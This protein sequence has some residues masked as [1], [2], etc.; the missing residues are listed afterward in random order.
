MRDPGEFSDVSQVVREDDFSS[1]A[2]RLIFAAVS[3]LIVSGKPAHPK[4]VADLLDAKERMVDV[5]G[6]AYIIDIWESFA[7]SKSAKLFAEIVRKK[8]NLRAVIEA[9]EVI[10]EAA[11]H[12]GAVDTEIVAEAEALIFDLSRDSRRTKTLDWQQCV[13]NALTVIDKRAG[14]VS[15][16]QD[17]QSILTGFPRLDHDTCGFHRRELIILAA[18]PSVGKTLVALN[19]VDNIAARGHKV[20]FASIEQG[21]VELVHRMLSRR[22]GIDSFKFRSGRFSPMEGD[23]LLNAK[24]AM[25]NHKLW[26]NDDSTQTL[27][28]V[29]S[30][31][32]RLKQRH[33]LDLVVVDYLQLMKAERRHKGTR[34]DEVGQL[35]RGLK[36]LA[37]DLDV[38]VMCLAQLN[39]GSENRTDRTPK[40]SDLR[41]S[42]EIEQD[43]DT[44][45][46]LHKP[47][48]KDKN[49][50]TDLLDFLIEKQRNGPCGRVPMIHKKATFEIKEL[51]ESI[52][53]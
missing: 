46:L 53:P 18:R 29:A 17:E 11:F 15:G 13:T 38:A 43:A 3:D 50:P 52:I 37:R 10:R 24:D 5:G 47:E 21:H 6:P 9:A 51:A 8:A 31:S 7:T 4:F 19:I 48:E 2:H 28:Y 27:G 39:R 44:V 35:T 1:F 22:S 32:R 30:E 26:I 36:A 16:G 12:P 34:N 14:R 49:R 20:F 42:G 33:G 25:N 45:F 23:D 41:D 40:L